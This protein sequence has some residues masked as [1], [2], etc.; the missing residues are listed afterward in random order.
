[1]FRA[2]Q[3]TLAAD[4]TTF[5]EDVFRGTGRIVPGITGNVTI[6]RSPNGGNFG[7][8]VLLGHSV[9]EF[10]S[11]F[12]GQI[13]RERLPRVLRRELQS[14]NIGVFNPR[15]QALRDIADVQQLVGAMLECLDSGGAIQASMR[16]R[17][18]AQQY[19]GTF[20]TAY[21]Q[22]AA[23]NPPPTRPHGIDAFVRAWG[24]R[25]SQAPQQSWPREWPLLELCF[26]LLAWFPRLRDDPEG[27][28]HLEAIARAI[29]QS[30]TFSPYRSLV[31]HGSGLHDRRSV[32]AALRDIFAQLAESAIDV[33]EEIMPSV[34][35][36]RFAMM[37]IHQAKGLEFPLVIVD[38][39]SDFR[40]NH[41]KNRFKRFPSN[42]AT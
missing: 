23:T 24:Q 38:V 34:P 40:T 12:M 36:D 5:L 25:R 2:D 33:D 28:V 20:R 32:E 14:R 37:T 26:T 8:A 22:Y 27:Q 42:R 11:S 35:R 19:L 1:M 10:T 6:A 18:V 7:D 31:L 16:L 3:N 9:N 4:L 30:A 13:P 29:A 17:G 21:A 15:G 41:A 39:A